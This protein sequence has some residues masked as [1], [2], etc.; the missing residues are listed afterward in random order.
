MIKTISGEIPFERYP[1]LF[2]NCGRNYNQISCNMVAYMG[3]LWIR[4]LL[5]YGNVIPL[6]G[7]SHWLSGK[8]STCRCRRHRFDP[9]IRK[10][11]W[12]RK[13]KPTPVFL[14]G[15]SHAERSLVGYKRV[16]HTFA[17]KQQHPTLGHMTCWVHYRLDFNLHSISLFDSLVQLNNLYKK[18]C[19]TLTCNRRHH[20][21]LGISS[22]CLVICSWSLVQGL[23]L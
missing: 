13:W 18:L 15:K 1:C 3:L 9:W 19:Y 21:F 4:C 12:R 10:V 5:L 22:D 11:P 14:P 6:W 2:D 23:G 20:A 16:R 17:T 8:A 7:L